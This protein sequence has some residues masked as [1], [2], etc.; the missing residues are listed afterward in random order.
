MLL[1]P[2]DLSYADFIQQRWDSYGRLVE[3]LASART[4]CGF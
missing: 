3:P 4:N 1:L 2:G